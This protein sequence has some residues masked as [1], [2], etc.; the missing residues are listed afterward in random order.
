M[1]SNWLFLVYK[2]ATNMFHICRV[3]SDISE[4]YSHYFR[5]DSH[6]F[7]MYTII[8]ANNDKFAFLFPKVVTH[9]FLISSLIVLDFSEQY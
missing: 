5:I 1:S 9:S 4:F 7:S 2:K 6:E 8:S 3:S